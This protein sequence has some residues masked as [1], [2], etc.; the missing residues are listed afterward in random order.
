MEKEEESDEDNE[1][2]VKN[3]GGKR[4]LKDRIKEEKDI[5]SK[6]KRM[7]ENKDTP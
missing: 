1:K 5:R 6:E 2:Q 7:R 4:G 3:K